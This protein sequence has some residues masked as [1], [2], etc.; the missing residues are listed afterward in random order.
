[1][2]MEPAVQP[3]GRTFAQLGSISLTVSVIVWVLRMWDFRRQQS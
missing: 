1:M 2:R 3:L